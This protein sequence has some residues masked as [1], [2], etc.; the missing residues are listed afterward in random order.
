MRSPCELLEGFI[1][2]LFRGVM[3]PLMD[4][5]LCSFLVIVEAMQPV[6]TAL[7]AGAFSP[8]ISDK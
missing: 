6:E 3:I 2:L 8:Q 4:S 1:K 7:C 5:H